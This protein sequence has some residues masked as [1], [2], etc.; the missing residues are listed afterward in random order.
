MDK[1][2]GDQ[3][4]FEFLD[5]KMFKEFLYDRVKPYDGI[6]QKFIDPDTIHN[7]VYRINWSPKLCLFEKRTNKLLIN[8]KSAD[9][10]ERSCT[11]EGSEIYSESQALRGEYLTQQM[12]QQAN[13]LAYHISNLT[14]ELKIVD[15]MVLNFKCDKNGQLWFLWC[16]GLRLKLS[17]QPNDG[18]V[19]KPPLHKN[20]VLKQKNSL[21]I[22][23]DLGTPTNIA[24]FTTNQVT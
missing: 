10:Y 6:L 18:A 9:P 11:Y 17:E 20:M 3:T 13:S 15:R 1:K 16:S 5:E 4:Y 14:F 19:K 2:Y 21:V 7:V 24:S 8:Q 12:Q 23:T 22:G